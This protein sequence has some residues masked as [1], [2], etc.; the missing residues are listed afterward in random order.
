MTRIDR[1]DRQEIERSGRVYF[2]FAIPTVAVGLAFAY[3]GGLRALAAA[4]DRSAASG[5]SR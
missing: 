4:E 2:W 5:V 3:V 1:T